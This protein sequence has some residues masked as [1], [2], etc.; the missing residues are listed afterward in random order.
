M[1]STTATSTPFAAALAAVIP[2]HAADAKM[3]VPFFA[4]ASTTRRSGT[5]AAHALALSH[6]SDTGAF[7]IGYASRNSPMLNDIKSNNITELVIQTPPPSSGKSS[8][9][10][11]QLWRIEG[12]CYVACSPQLLMRFPPPRITAEDPRLYWEQQRLSVFLRLSPAMRALNLLPPPG[13]RPAAHP[14]AEIPDS[15]EPVASLAA[16]L[17]GNLSLTEGA[18]TG[19]SAASPPMSPQMIRSNGATAAATPQATAAAAA[20]G[21]G[22][23]MS[24]STE[25]VDF[26]RALDNFVLVVVKI[27]RVDVLSFGTTVADFART[28]HAVSKEG[29]WTS[30]IVSP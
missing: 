26:D 15:P 7:L 12:K 16:R 10:K 23:R 4:A 13:D 17:I 11:Q 5:T 25:L 22:M 1:T 24:A 18:L 29:L 2:H 3:A 19:S 28:V 8:T 14:V 6:V 27:A 9:A 21:Q 30:E 20:A